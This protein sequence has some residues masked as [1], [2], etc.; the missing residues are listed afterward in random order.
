MTTITTLDV[1]TASFI[2]ALIS[3]GVAATTAWLTL[4]QRGTV[5]MVRPSLIA[6]LDARGTD[7][8]KVWFR[9]LMYSTSRRGGVIESMYVRLRRGES[10]QNFSFW[11]C[12]EKGDL[13]GGCGLYVAHTGIA[14]NH[15]FVLPKDGS[16][17]EFLPGDYIIDV[18]CVLVGSDSPLLLA[19]I[20]LHLTEP[21]AQ[22]LKD[23]D[24]NVYFDWW[25]DSAR[26][27]AH[28]V[29]RPP[30]PELSEVLTDLFTGKP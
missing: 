1:A 15:H 4:W 13:A 29:R 3:M 8:P 26:Y 24:E 17:F 18:F 22:S 25:P 6:F 7:G 19:H 20:P 28:V 23:Q 9:T 10:Q 30:R 27:N 12:G 11:V 16:R 5:K 14:L 2:V 21:H